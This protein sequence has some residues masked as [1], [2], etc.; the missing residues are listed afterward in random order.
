MGLTL[1]LFSINVAL[2]IIAYYLMRIADAL[3]E[4][5]K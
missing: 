1:S 2:M 4:G 3:K 5:S